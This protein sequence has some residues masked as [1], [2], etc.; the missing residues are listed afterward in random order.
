MGFRSFIWDF[1]GGFD[2][3]LFIIEMLGHSGS[4][5]TAQQVVMLAVL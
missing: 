1:I 2:R 4:E 5:K 3:D